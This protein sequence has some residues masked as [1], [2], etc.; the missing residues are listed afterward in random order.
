MRLVALDV[1]EKRIGVATADTTVKLAVPHSTIVVDGG[2]F[3]KI[4]EIMKEN[5]A[6]HLVVGLPR[7][8]NGE[9]TAQSKY[10]RKFVSEFQ[11]YCV[12]N[13]YGKP[14]VKFQDESLTS[15]VAEQ[16]LGQNKRK[17]RQK[18]D[19]DRE[20]ATLIMQ[21]FLDSFSGEATV[22]KATKNAKKKSKTGRRILS[23]LAVILALL[24]IAVV[25]VITWYADSI[26]ARTSIEEC[27]G[28]VGSDKCIYG[29]FIV[30]ESESVSTI[31]A[32]LEEEGFI[33]SALAFKVYLR[34]N[35]DKPVLRIGT[36][37]ISSSM[38]VAE[39][40]SV[41]ETGSIAATFRITFLPGGTIIDAKKALNNAGYRNE[42]IEAAFSKTYDHPV[43]AGKPEN[44]TVE[45]YIFGETYEFYAT[46]SVEDI[47]TRTFDQLYT[48]VEQEDLINKYSAQ[49]LT[50][51]EGITLASIVQKEAYSADQPQVAQV[52]LSRMA[53]GMTLGSDAIIGYR[54]DQLNPN[55]DKSDMS[56]L[57]LSVIPCPWNSRSCTGLPPSPISNPGK[58]ALLAVATPAAGDYL[59]F[60]TGDDNKMY[61]ARNNADHEKN[62]RD[63]CKTMC[64]IL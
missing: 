13:S 62:I 21:D 33:K 49:G 9:E 22:Q 59:Y 55:R 39:I 16:N 23:I 1:G 42:D 6:K 53:A 52:F 26:R 17:K 37:E 50:L 7:N 8:N 20:A 3:S 30:H 46:A 60:L 51:Y 15:V 34:V 5:D 45:G 61:Y 40:V 2:E 12:K 10:V 25:G 47:L 28:I 64:S 31:A 36:Y 43:M 57:N 41:L 24:I 14:M 11:E 58:S 44:G 19:I 56:Y 38:S 35:N 4:A 29:E 32:R 63:H 18:S 48:I 54:A 27:S